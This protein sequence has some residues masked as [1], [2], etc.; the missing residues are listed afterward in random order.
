VARLTLSV[1]LQRQVVG[2]RWGW[3]AALGSG[4]L[5]GGERGPVCR[6]AGRGVR[7]AACGTSVL[8]VLF[9][10]LVQST[11]ADLAR[12]A[13]HVTGCW[14][15]VPVGSVAVRCAIRNQFT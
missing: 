15:S 13:E 14:F 5:P 12:P 1:L 4:E 2:A 6:G 8:A 9:P 7:A 3:A 11:R 10:A